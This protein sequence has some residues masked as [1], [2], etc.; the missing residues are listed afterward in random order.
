MGFFEGCRFDGI[1]LYLSNLL[2][3]FGEVFIFF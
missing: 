1:Y 2:C 3:D